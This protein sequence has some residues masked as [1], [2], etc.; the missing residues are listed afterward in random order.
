[1]TLSNAQGLCQRVA[2]VI[3]II[4]LYSTLHIGHC[5]A[6]MTALLSRHCVGFF[7]VPPD[8]Q[9]PKTA[10]LALHCD[11]WIAVAVLNFYS[12]ILRLRSIAHKILTFNRGCLHLALMHSYT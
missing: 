5:A 9:P 7:G 6:L 2:I 3:V 11:P 1:M 4:A 10:P 12:S 8:C